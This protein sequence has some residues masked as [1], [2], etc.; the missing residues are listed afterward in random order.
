[1]LR[2]VGFILLTND[3]GGDSPALIPLA[4]A[5]AELSP[6]RVVVPDG[7]RSWIGKAISRW[8]DVET[9]SDE[10]DGI[11]MIRVS[12]APADCVNLGVHG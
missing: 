4:R 3:D 11:E 10:R 5:I 7:E 2:A 12:G 1:M 9:R 8:Q 6:V